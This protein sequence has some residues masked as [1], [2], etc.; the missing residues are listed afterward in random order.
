MVGFDFITF[1]NLDTSQIINLVSTKAPT[2]DWLI[3]SLHWGNEY[4]SEP[5]TW[6]V[7]LAHQLVDAGADIIHGHHPHVWQDSETYQG[8]PIFYSL[9]NFVFD[10]SWSY[11]T[12][13][14]QLVRMTVTKNEIK[15]INYFPY[16]IYANSQPRL[17]PKPSLSP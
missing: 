14:S 6:R 9:G 16:E 7:K 8:K 1:P 10:Q 12:S 17:M 5:E 11:A 2:V 15:S 4:L 3:V 13:H